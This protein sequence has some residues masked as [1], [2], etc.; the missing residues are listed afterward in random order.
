YIY[1]NAIFSVYMSRYEGFGIPILESMGHGLPVIVSDIPVFHEVAGKSALYVPLDNP[2]E[3]SSQMRRLITDTS[4]RKDLT[5]HGYEQITSFSWRHS[6]E[7]ILTMLQR[8][9]S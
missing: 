2:E 7:K 6:A 1:K 8:M 4:L 3:L 9:A 5:S